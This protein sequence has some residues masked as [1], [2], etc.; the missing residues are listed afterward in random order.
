MGAVEGNAALARLAAERLSVGRH[1]VKALGWAG[2]IWGETVA[3]AIAWISLKGSRDPQTNRF[4]ASLDGFYRRL[5]GDP[6]GAGAA[7]SHERM[8]QNVWICSA[9][10]LLGLFVMIKEFVK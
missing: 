7:Y 5:S 2:L 4:T 3:I 10:A 1:A 9:I 6:T 8:L